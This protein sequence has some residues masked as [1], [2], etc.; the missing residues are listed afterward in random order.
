M[1]AP[2]AIGGL[3]IL[4]RLWRRSGRLQV[5]VAV[6]V[7]VI[8]SMAGQAAGRWWSIRSPASALAACGAALFVVSDALL[9][10]NRFG[11]PFRS[12]Q[13]LIHSSY[14]LAQWLIAVS[15]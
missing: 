6:Y 12:A 2:F 9:A 11:R 13:A 15:V 14:F 8:V 4:G 3:A 10:V 7:A 1:F 5:P